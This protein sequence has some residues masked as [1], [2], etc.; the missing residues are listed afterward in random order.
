MVLDLSA[1]LI[2]KMSKGLTKVRIYS[3]F[4][5][6]TEKGWYNNSLRKHVKCSLGEDELSVNR[7]NKNL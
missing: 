4:N 1:V 5:I 6:G 7:P 2:W 3:N